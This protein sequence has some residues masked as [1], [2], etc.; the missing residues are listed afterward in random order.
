[1]KPYA[2]ENDRF[3]VSDRR[4]HEDGAVWGFWAV[5]GQR[6]KSDVWSDWEGM[7]QCQAGDTIGLVLD[8]VAD[9]LSVREQSFP[10]SCFLLSE[11]IT[12]ADSTHE[13]SSIR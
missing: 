2:A 11:T 7:E 9:T 3:W 5:T 12:Q 8:L 13:L 10:L 1:M 4:G 6:V